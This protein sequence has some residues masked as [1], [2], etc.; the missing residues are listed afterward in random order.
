MD[1]NGRT[2]DRYT[3]APT[4]RSALFLAVQ[5]GRENQANACGTRRTKCLS[6]PVPC[7]HL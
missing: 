4:V 3:I 2:I 7:C 6:L 1:R 5:A